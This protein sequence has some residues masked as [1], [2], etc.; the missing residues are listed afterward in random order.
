LV[1]DGKLTPSLFSLTAGSRLQ[2][3]ARAKGSFALDESKRNHLMVATGTGIAPFRSIVATQLQT[4][5]PHRFTLIHGASQAH[6]LPFADELM[7]TSRSTDRL[8]YIP[9]VSGTMHPA[10]AGRSGRAEVIAAGLAADL[11]REGPLQV[12]A[13]GNAGMIDSLTRLLRPLGFTVS[14][15]QFY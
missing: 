15:E 9:T 2:L 5:S 12:Y 13:C 1:P 7:A 10:W 8:R 6:D 4:N 3:G 14:Y 11:A